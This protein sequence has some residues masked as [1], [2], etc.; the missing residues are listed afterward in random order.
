MYIYILAIA[1][2]TVG[3]NWLNFLDTLSPNAK[4]VLLN[5]IPEFHFWGLNICV[6][7]DLRDSK[8]ME[9]MKKPNK[10]IFHNKKGSFMDIN[11]KK[12][13]FNITTFVKFGFQNWFH[14]D[15]LF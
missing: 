11:L 14:N 15:T 1:G 7:F 13:I 6:D 5:E 3:P 12:N 8:K 2:K 9:N 4:R 10:I